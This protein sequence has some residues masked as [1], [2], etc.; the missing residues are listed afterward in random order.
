M[1]KPEKVEKTNQKQNDTPGQLEELQNI[2]EELRSSE[3]LYRTLIETSSDG[4][5]MLDLHGKIKYANRKKAQMFGYDDPSELIGIRGLSLLL[6][7]DRAKV[8]TEFRKLLDTGSIRN[9]EFRVMSRDG[10]VFPVEFNATVIRDNDGNPLQIMDV[11]RDIS[12][13]KSREEEIVRAKEEWERTFDAIPDLVAIIDNQHRIVRVNK[14]MA[15]KMGLSKEECLGVTC[16]SAIHGADKPPD[17][18]PHAK[19]LADGKEHIAEIFEEGLGGDFIVTTSPLHGTEGNL[20]SS[21]H[22][23][24]NITEC[25]QTE[26]ILQENEE[27]Y[28]SFISQSTEG[29]WRFELEKPIAIDLK[30]DD[31]IEHFYK[32]S[33]LAECNDAMAKMYGYSKAEELTGVRL[34]EFL[35]RSIPEN[36]EYLKAFIRSGYC[37]N[38]AESIEPD[39]KG[40]IK[41]YLNNLVGIVENGKL[42]RAWGTQRDI[43][44]QRKTIEALKSNEER[45]SLAQRA[46][47]IGSWDWDILTGKLEWSEQ[48]EPI[49]GFEPG[50]FCGT[51]DAFLECV[52]PEDRELV[53]NSTRAAVI[54]GKEYCIEHRVVRSDGT[55]R[56]V[57]EDGEV[58]RDDNG[59]AFRMIGIVQDITE[60]KQSE[61]LLKGSEELSR[62][63]LESTAD[64]I[65]VVNNDGKVI[66]SNKRFAKMWRIPNEL[67]DLKDD[68]KLLNHVLEQLQDPDEFLAKVQE[69][70]DSTEED[71]DT[72]NFRDERVFERYS[73]AMIHDGEVVGRVWSIRD[74]TEQNRVEATQRFLFEMTDATATS[75]DL[76]QLIEIIY[77]KLGKL[78]NTSNFHVALY[79][80][81]TSTYSFPF[82]VDQDAVLFNQDNVKL[83]KSLTD[84]VQRTGKAIMVDPELDD[85]LQKQ[86]EIVEV[87]KRALQWLGAPLTTDEGVIGVVAVQTYDNPNLYTED[88]LK[89]LNSIA[90]HIAI[91]VDR[92]RSDEALQESELKF[93]SIAENIPGAVYDYTILK[94]GRRLNQFMGP[95]MEDI[96][97]QRDTKE[98][99]GDIDLLL[100]KIHE[101]D[102]EYFIAAARL[103]KETGQ[104]FNHEYRFRTKSGDYIWVHDIGRA[105]PL[106]DDAY[107][108]QGVLIDVTKQKRA[109]EEH[110]RLEARFQEAQKK[111][112]LSILAGGIAHDFN[113]LLVGIM[114]NSSLALLDL[115]PVSPARESIEAIEKSAQ[116]AADLTKQMLAYSGKGQFIVED[117]NL[118]E[119]VQEMTHFVKASISKKARLELKLKKKLPAI[120]GDLTQFRQLVMN[121]L[122]NASEALE[123][124]E[125]IITMTSGV[126]RCDQDFLRDT[127]LGESLKPGDFVFLRIADTGCGMDEETLS[128]IFDPFFSTKFT[129]RGLGLAAILGIVDGHKGTIEISS[130]PGKGTSFTAYFPLSTTAIPSEVEE[131]EIEE[132]MEGTGTI[133][134]V[135]DEKVIRTLV[136]KICE[137]FGYKVLTAS[138]GI[139]G[140]DLYRAHSDEISTVLLDLTMPRMD[141]KEAFE[142][143]KEI[144][145]DAVIILT[146]GY[147]EEEARERF[148]GKGIAG[149]IK[150][151]YKPSELIQQIQDITSK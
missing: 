126:R 130:V 76:R 21:V 134:I 93:R 75:Q 22:V 84:Y 91:A 103:A 85:K 2:V 135:E 115:S 133:L 28:R 47:N 151:P 24:R 45:Y 23:A 18:C 81:K 62:S 150:K 12:D 123:E 40:N 118:T 19:L 65:L 8:L 105:T 14:A 83:E 131:P 5:C 147:N 121:L 80:E 82:D 136:E 61:Q 48:C 119:L 90:E 137:R 30:E 41:Y 51:N 117:F 46:A 127:K 116:R 64:G 142:K 27:R 63:I 148:A 33:Y 114:G 20:I 16:Y 56:W 34:G 92:K 140:V 100:S 86:G 139:E 49:F 43:T 124:E 60:R 99:E 97:G 111:E 31:Q 3:T 88:D 79:D 145:P 132:I 25:K 95:G 39:K 144:K 113:N 9:L 104:T 89:L 108:W 146:S 69:L 7:E 68:D 143:I 102:V 96:I 149:F 17:F 67:I 112:S 29:I 15:E 94:D 109:I 101:D 32:Y 71:F 72:L 74:I 110:R 35:V 70:Y 26:K 141:G 53:Y 11:M 10:R 128:K 58:F 57:S 37:L 129:G 42:I 4:V 44:K 54:E 125:G 98:S 107:Q 120:K 77:K 138:D 106:D 122:I 59:K 55:V 52:H 36:I 87:G 6:R 78:I 13:R 1:K 38:D 73:T 66:H 50:S